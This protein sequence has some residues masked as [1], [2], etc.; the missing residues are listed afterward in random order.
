MGKGGRKFIS[1]ANS[2]LGKLST[3]ELQR[4]AVAYGVKVEGDD[5]YAR[6]LPIITY[7]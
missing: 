7:T 5:R 1:P 4:W 6:D 2:Q 3:E